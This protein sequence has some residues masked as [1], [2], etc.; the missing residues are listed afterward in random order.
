[1][2]SITAPSTHQQQTL[3][4]G[5][6]RA[7]AQSR[8][9]CE[10]L[11][12]ETPRLLVLGSNSTSENKIPALRLQESTLTTV[13]EITI[14][15]TRSHKIVVPSRFLR[16]SNRKPNFSPPYQISPC[17]CSNTVVHV[18]AGRVFLANSQSFIV[19]CR[20]EP[21]ILDAVSSTSSSPQPASQL[22]RS[23]AHS[24][25]TILRQAQRAGISLS[26]SHSH[27]L[28]DSSQF[29]SLRFPPSPSNPSTS[30]DLF[31]PPC[32]FVPFVLQ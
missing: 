11:M 2:S 14:I 6:V 4:L 8:E 7:P 29:N 23:P 24:L 15:Q 32:S 10:D 1:M 22:Q 27:F 9:S 13:V 31:K 19:T 30:P 5:F 28:S 20:A 21:A 3:I 16:L 26:A 25:Q 12:F 18:A 17:A